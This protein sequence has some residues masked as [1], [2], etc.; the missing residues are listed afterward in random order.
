[1]KRK[2]L[3][4]TVFYFFLLFISYSELF[5]QTS[6][7]CKIFH[8]LYGIAQS[9][10]VIDDSIAISLSSFTGPGGR[11]IEELSADLNNDGNIEKVVFLKE[12][13]N[14]KSTHYRIVI[15]DQN[16]IPVDLSA[17][18]PPS[19]NNTQLIKAGL[20]P[21][22]QDE[23]GIFIEVEVN[24]QG[25]KRCYQY[26]YTFSQ[27]NLSLFYSV[28][29]REENTQ[30]GTDLHIRFINHSNSIALV[31]SPEFWVNIPPQI[32]SN[33]HI[34]KWSI[35][36]EIWFEPSYFGFLPFQYKT[37]FQEYRLNPTELYYFYYLPS[38]PE[39]FPRNSWIDI[40]QH[41][42]DRLVKLWSTYLGFHLTPFTTGLQE[43]DPSFKV[44]GG[45]TDDNMELIVF[46]QDSEIHPQKD[47]LRI[48]LASP[49]DPTMILD[50]SVY[51]DISKNDFPV[52]IFS[53][54]P[55][56][57]DIIAHSLSA[58][59]QRLIFLVEIPLSVLSTTVVNP[60]EH[61]VLRVFYKYRDYD[62]DGIIHLSAPGKASL[63]DPTSWGNVITGNLNLY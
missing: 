50:I 2:V 56:S 60:L 15:T 30:G 23:I 16:Y 22:V 8:S 49:E 10:I 26:L 37:N 55:S 39:I 5:S 58:S 45:I 21:L 46:I 54:I 42:H 7:A 17:F 51:P 4:L 24:D 62:H 43:F 63:E 35:P 34:S 25:L 41:Q 20:L 19:G 53:S 9:N 47:L 48:V 28:T 27:Q 6:P 36:G 61:S 33:F 57:G 18:F 3:Q 40:H 44:I 14:Q 29:S 31:E 32:D 12:V 52:E 38:Q 11:R 59:D 13:I 1:M